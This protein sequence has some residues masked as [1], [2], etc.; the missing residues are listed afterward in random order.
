MGKLSGLKWEWFVALAL[1]VAALFSATYKLT[2]SPPTWYDEGYYNQVAE[3]LALTG[4]QQIQIAPGTYVSSAYVTGGYPFLFPVSQSFK[5]FGIGLLQARAVMVVFIMLFLGAAFLVARSLFGLRAALLS[6]A[7]LV[8]FPVLYGNG[9]N[10]LGEVPGLFYFMGFLWFTHRIEKEEFKGIGNYIFAGI[11]AGFCVATKPLF[12][13][14]GG[15]LVL[16][17]IFSRRRIKFYL[18]NISAAFAAFLLPVALWFFMQ[19]SGHDSPQAVLHYYA[20]PYNIANISGMMFANFLRF[21][22]EMSPAYFIILFAVWAGSF[23]LRWRKFGRQSI[24]FVESVSFFFALLVSLAYLRTAGWYR[25]FFPANI[26]ALIFLPQAIFVTGKSIFA[27]FYATKERLICG[28]MVAAVLLLVLFQAYQLGFRSWVA[29]HYGS[30]RTEKLAEY[31]KEYPRDKTLFVYNVP[32]IVVFL[33]TTNY[34]QF[35]KPTDTISLGQEGLGIIAKGVPD[36][37]VLA[38]AEFDKHP[39]DFAGYKEKDR[40]D[41]YIVLEKK[42]K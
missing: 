2:E 39:L 5:V 9:K 4:E 20:N 11:F 14:I 40:V 3:N 26:M 30:T 28:G 8:S 12:L 34:Y 1:F 10:V 16:A 24:S 35:L 36:G 23:V 31:F 38:A 29:E 13:L 32:E 15:A 22:T 19:F 18:G 21:F 37:I 17:F 33:P 6:L 42:Q 41:D 27:R 7:L 25:Y